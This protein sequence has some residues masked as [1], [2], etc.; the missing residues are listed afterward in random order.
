MYLAGLDTVVE[1]QFAGDAGNGN[2]IP[3]VWAQLGGLEL[4]TATQTKDNEDSTALGLV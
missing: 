3:R 2:T 4:N 1:A